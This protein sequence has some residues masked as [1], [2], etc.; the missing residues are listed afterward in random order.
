MIANRLKDLWAAG[1]P[2]INGWCSI[3]NPFT[4]EIMANIKLPDVSAMGQQ[5]QSSVQQKVQSYYQ[6]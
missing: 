5:I 2:T 1:R 3:G 4:A 6:R